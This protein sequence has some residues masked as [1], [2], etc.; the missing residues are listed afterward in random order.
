MAFFFFFIALDI[1]SKTG[2]DLCD[3]LAYRERAKW[4]DYAEMNVFPGKFIKDKATLQTSWQ[5]AAA[6]TGSPHLSP[7]P[8]CSFRESWESLVDGNGWGM[9]N[10]WAWE[11]CLPSLD[12]GQGLAL[13]ATGKWTAGVQRPAEY[14]IESRF[15][16]WCPMKESSIAIPTQGSL[17]SVPARGTCASRQISIL[18]I[19]SLLSF[20]PLAL[21]TSCETSKP[22]HSQFY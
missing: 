21:S 5:G 4:G 10:E 20:S 12:T 16:S 13:G 7:G 8:P 18:R 17:H 22:A 14:G 11:P 15:A 9:C 3:L 1:S 6:D 2:I 19:S